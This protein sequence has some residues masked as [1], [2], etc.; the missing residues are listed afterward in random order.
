[1]AHYPKLK[2]LTG[3]YKVYTALLTQTGTDVPVATVLENT[4]GGDITITRV[5]TGNYLFS[6]TSLFGT[7]DKC[8]IQ[9][10]SNLNYGD[11]VI[12]SIYRAKYSDSSSIYLET[13]NLEGG[14]LSLN[15]WN[16][17]YTPIEIRVYN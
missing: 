6:S 2:S 7:V 10:S 15:D 3:S 17:T 12:V 11:D 5:S 14:V 8:F 9:I 13:R 1:M 16:L 4:L